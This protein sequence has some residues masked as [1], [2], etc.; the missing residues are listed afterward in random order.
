MERVSV[1][2]YYS[3]GYNYKLYRQTSINNTV[4]VCISRLEEYVRFI[5]TLNLVVTSNIVSEEVDELIDEL[6]EFAPSEKVSAVLV[7]KILRVFEKADVCLDSELQLKKLLILTPKRFESEVLLNKPQSLLAKRVWSKLTEQAKTDFEAASKCIAMSLPT[8]SAFHLM[9]CVE[10]CVRQLYFHFKDEKLSRFMW[11][12]ITSCLSNISPPNT[13]PNKELLDNL[14][15]IRRNYRNPTQHPEK[16][17][18]MD[19]AQDLLNHSI[20]AINSIY[21]EIL[22]TKSSSLPTPQL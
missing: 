8:A 19:E 7:S 18:S 15:L 1:Y 12:D 11:G 2:D 13:K 6:K 20:V 17:Y 14:D 3:F 16:N 9:R 21:Y 22:N 4:K 5:D 10:E